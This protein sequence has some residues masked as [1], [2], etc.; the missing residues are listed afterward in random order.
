MLVCLFEET[1][2]DLAPKSQQGR[3]QTLL[4]LATHCGPT[5]P[6]DISF[7][8]KLSTPVYEKHWLWGQ[9]W[10]NL[11]PCSDLD[12]KVVYIILRGLVK[13]Q[14]ERECFGEPTAPFSRNGQRAIAPQ[15]TAD[16]GHAPLSPDIRKV[17]ALEDGCQVW[18]WHLA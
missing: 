8:P 10:V 4:S 16:F 14:L 3:C 6:A 5:I 15:V 1:G 18:R 2:H 17:Q 13:C 9:T 12:V 7:L 11:Y